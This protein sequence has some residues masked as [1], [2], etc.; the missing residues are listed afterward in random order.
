[1]ANVE[2]RRVPLNTGANGQD[3]L[4]DL[5]LG[6]AVDQGL[7]VELLR[8]NAVH[9]RDQATQDMVLALELTG[10]FD[11]NHITG[12]R[13][14]TEGLAIA[15]GGRADVADRFRREVEA[16]RAEPHL[17][18]GVEE[19]LGK[20]L[21]LRLGPF[22]QV[23]GKALGTFGADAGEPLE[24][25]DEASE[26][27][28]IDGGVLGVGAGKSGGSGGFWFSMIARSV[29]QEAFWRLRSLLDVR[30]L[31]GQKLLKSLVRA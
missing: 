23:E 27:A 20:G 28:G 26:G 7:D 17:L 14:D 12:V 30:Y 13:H 29:S 11:R 2:R 10:F 24:L 3:G 18:L 9:G 31:G 6:N 19:S 21:D 15:I 4:L 5:L 16:D 25:V 22:E 1:M 8:T